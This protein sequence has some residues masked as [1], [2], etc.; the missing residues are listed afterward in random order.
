M[1][2]RA[3]LTYLYARR[4][5]GVAVKGPAYRL[6]DPLPPDAEQ[7]LE[8]FRNFVRFVEAKRDGVKYRPDQLR[9]PAGNPDGGQWTD[10]GGGGGDKPANRPLL[11]WTPSAG[12]ASDAPMPIG[13]VGFSE[14]ERKMTAQEFI[15]KNCDASVLRVFPGEFLDLSVGEIE[16]MQHDK[17]NKY[18]PQTSA[19][20]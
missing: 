16:D 19:A 4:R 10:E 2:D 17:K 13:Q 18:L 14:A 6:K 12:T 11:A 7:A 5:I 9:V 8:P 20:S 15:A 3:I 1:H